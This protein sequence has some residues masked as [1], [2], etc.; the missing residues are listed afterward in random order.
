[1]CWVLEY[2][3]T[4]NFADNQQKISFCYLS[5]NALREDWRRMKKPNLACEKIGWNYL[6]RTGH[7]MMSQVWKPHTLS[8]TMRAASVDG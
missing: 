3:T 7:R 1:M 4:I 5:E 2:D 8:G 6:N